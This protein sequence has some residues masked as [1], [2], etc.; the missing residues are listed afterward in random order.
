MKGELNLHKQLSF[1]WDETHAPSGYMKHFD[2]ESPHLQVTQ[3]GRSDFE[4]LP[5]ESPQKFCTSHYE[6][7]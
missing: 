1:V 5:S 3:V 6:M 7:P 2:L 4:C